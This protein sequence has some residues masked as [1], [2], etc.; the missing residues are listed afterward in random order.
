MISEMQYEGEDNLFLFLVAKYY[1]NT[2]KIGEVKITMY[3]T[4]PW[5]Y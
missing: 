2:T 3:E 1:F 5:N 4:Y